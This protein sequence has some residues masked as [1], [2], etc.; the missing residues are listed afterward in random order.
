MTGRT[1]EF[2]K[3]AE[4]R[5]I[6]LGLDRM[7]ALM[8]L[9]G[10]P[11]EGPGY[12]H[13]AG[14][15]GKGSV[16]G[17]ISCI[18]KN[19]GY[20]TG[21]YNSPAVTGITD[22]YNINGSTITEE[23]YEGYLRR[24]ADASYLLK[25]KGYE[26]PTLFEVQ[27]AIA[28]LYFSERSCDMVVLE[29]GMG[30]R[31]DATNI[32]TGT[33][34]SVLTSISEDHLGMIGNDLSGIAHTKAGIIKKGSFVVSAPQKSEVLW[35]IQ[36]QAE[37]FGTE[38]VIVDR[39][40]IRLKSLSLYGSEFSYK[41]L[42]GLKLNMGG[43]YQPE[44]AAVA[45]EACGCLKEAGYNISEEDIRS[46]LEEAVC[47]FRLERILTDPEF[48]LDGAHNPGAADGLHNTIFPLRDNVSLTL[49]MGMFKDKD[50]ARVC[51]RLAPLCKRA[52][53]LQTRDNERALS[54]FVLRDE[55]ERCGV[56]EAVT[57]DSVQEAVK[58]ALYHAEGDRKAGERPLIIACG[59][60]SFLY[61]V[62]KCC[63]GQRG[64]S[65]VYRKAEI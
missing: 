17:Y 12:I 28:F 21:C 51:K 11:Q 6:D 23:E 56:K 33:L 43:E 25:D 32:V 22:Q 13:V 15:N 57:A 38:P 58:T 30:G 64:E 61:E 54:R 2:L 1:E 36:R 20:I 26:D 10:D 65:V 39:G 59:S 45:I 53:A 34:V 37:S 9:L 24:V 63:P 19:A 55:L 60:F 48:I 7:T 31:D 42:E 18:L 50:Y 27:T 3:K 47:P 14:T 16:C 46:G 62:K 4:S 44:N 52:I 41:G 40:D 8:E 29:T 5:G 35:V 49:I